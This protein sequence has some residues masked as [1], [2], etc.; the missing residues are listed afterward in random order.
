M[1]MATAT[2]AL[3]GLGSNLGDRKTILE[4]AITALAETPGVDVRAVSTFHET[5]PVGGPEG[6]GAFLNAAAM[7]ATTLDAEPLLDVLNGVEERAKRVRTVRWGARTLDLDLLL[8]GESVVRTRRLTIPHPRMAL[9]RFVLAPAHEI[10]PSA[11]DPMTT[12]TIA[13]LLANIDHR[14]SYLAFHGDD[15]PFKETVFRRVVAELQADGSASS[16]FDPGAPIPVPLPNPVRDFLQLP[17]R[18]IDADRWVV[19]DF[20]LPLIWHTGSQEDA[21]RTSERPGPERLDPSRA[22]DHLRTLQGAA[23]RLLRPTFAVILKSALDD[24][25]LAG[26]LDFPHL[27]ID[28]CDPDRAVAEVLAACAATR[29]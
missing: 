19:T 2:P 24:E 21:A 23:P 16:G 3:I 11:I 5:S 10:A 18:A 7:L 27:V 1:A 13:E 22:S 25:T 17:T 20:C 29:S 8:F 14:P 28:S 6:Q 26:V 4:A 9:R 15:G 12:R